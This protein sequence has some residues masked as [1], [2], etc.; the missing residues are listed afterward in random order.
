M[1]MIKTKNQMMT[2]DVQ[3]EDGPEKSEHEYEH[4]CHDSSYMMST[5]SP[6]ILVIS[7]SLKY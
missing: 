2:S 6:K 4:S 7:R 1:M 5:L 3:V